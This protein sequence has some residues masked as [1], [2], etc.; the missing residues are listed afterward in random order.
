[1]A[2]PIYKRILLKIS[3]EFFVGRSSFGIDVETIKNITL[4]IQNV[5]KLGVQIALVLGGGN[6]LR[7]IDLARNGLDRVASDQMGM[8]ATIMNGIALRSELTQQGIDTTLMSSVTIPTFVEKF[9][10]YRAMKQL[11]DG[12]VLIF[13]GGIGCP[14]FSTDSAASLHAIEVG[15]NIVFKATKVDGIY[16]DDPLKN[17]KAELLKKLTHD[18]AIR[19]QLKVMDMAALCLCR[20]HHMPIRVFNMNKPGLLEK[21]LLGADE[22]TLVS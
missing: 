8:L 7:G 17:P 2:L 12:T 6:F 5:Q 9:E 4:D 1:M 10:R 3:G 11:N 15:A 16:S 19:R 18:E 21:I 14:L 13:S 20:D 22:G